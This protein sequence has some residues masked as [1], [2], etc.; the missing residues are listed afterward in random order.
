MSVF[1]R[2]LV[3]VGISEQ[4]EHIEKQIVLV[5]LKLRKAAD[6]KL[7]EPRSFWLQVDCYVHSKLF[8]CF[9]LLF[10]CKSY[11]TSWIIEWYWCFMNAR[12]T[13][14]RSWRHCRAKCMSRLHWTTAHAGSPSPRIQLWISGMFTYWSWFSAESCRLNKHCSPRFCFLS[15]HMHHA[16]VCMDINSNCV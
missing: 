5:G 2:A 9:L 15:L 4:P 14:L 11:K 10:L 16:F 12:Y 6:K 8:Q 7:K 13:S 3:N 1:N